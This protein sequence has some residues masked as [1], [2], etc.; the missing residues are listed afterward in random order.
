[1]TSHRRT[2]PRGTS[3]VLAPNQTSVPAWMP[4]LCVP[5]YAAAIRVRKGTIMTM[6]APDRISTG[7]SPRLVAYLAAAAFAIAALWSALVAEHVTVAAPPR[8]V[9][10][11]P[12]D[13]ALHR[14]YSWFVTTLPQER[15]NTGIAIVGM[16]CLAVV[17]AFSV[18][19][20]AGCPGTPS[21]SA[22]SPG[23]SVTSCNS[24]RTGR[25]A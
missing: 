4:A 15:F 18:T 14:G 17:A 9:P 23:P 22:R 6:T 7:H 21:G 5:A 19:A 20:W 1:M 25:S 16:L 2:P 24:A 3:S 11:E 13:A 12:V 8:P 10:G